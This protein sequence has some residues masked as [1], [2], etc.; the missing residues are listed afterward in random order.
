[1][2]KLIYLFFALLI[3]SCSGEDDESVCLVC[4]NMGFQ[5]EDIH[6][7]L[8]GLISCASFEGEEICE[9]QTRA[10]MCFPNTVPIRSAPL[11]KTSLNRIKLYWEER[12][13]ICTLK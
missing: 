9:G 12:G 1:M 4:T 6:S 10:A 8:G 13:A 7:G 3:F 11:T 2:K 5:V